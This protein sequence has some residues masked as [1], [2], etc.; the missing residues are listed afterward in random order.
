MSVMQMT[1]LESPFPRV[2][3]NRPVLNPDRIRCA[4][5]TAGLSKVQLADALGVTPRTI[6][7]YDDFTFAL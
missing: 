2:E 1:N 4:R 3:A 7:N 5:D 6:T